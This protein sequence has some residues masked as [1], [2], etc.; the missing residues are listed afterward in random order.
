ML[1]T[2]AIFLK[3]KT[4]ICHNH[5]CIKMFFTNIVVSSRSLH[6]V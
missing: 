3:S 2:D 1:K 4:V 5:K 6:E